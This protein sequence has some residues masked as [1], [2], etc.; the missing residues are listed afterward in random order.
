MNSK[1][2]KLSKTLSYI[3]RHNPSQYG[4]ILDE[5][6]NVEIIDL[7][8]ALEKKGFYNLSK[9][10]LE[11]LAQTTDKKR[12]EI[13]GDKIKALYGHSVKDNIIREA[14]K[15][16]EILY[17]GTISYVIPKIKEYGLKPMNRQ[18]VH[19]SSDLKTAK[20]VG[21]R[22]KGDLIILKVKAKKAYEQ[23][24]QFYYANDNTWLTDEL[25]P[26]W[27]IFPEKML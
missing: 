15:P 18:Y 10:D 6:G 23:G 20:I 4:L 12:F 13:N 21:N 27:I 14:T 9:S 16:P 25:S 5:Q 24:Q 17:H 8:K 11:Y 1:Q 7:I 22:R 19:L 2:F 26:N 3:L